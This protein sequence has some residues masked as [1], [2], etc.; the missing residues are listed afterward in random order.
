MS[1]LY[2]HN[3]II[4]NLGDEIM[5]YILDKNSEIPLYSQ[6]KDKIINKINEG[7]Y[8]VGE[9]LPSEKEL[10]ELYDVS[11][12]TVRQAID[13]LVRENY[14]EIKRG[15]GTFVKQNKK[16]NIWGL[17][18]LRSFEE[19]AKRHGL[20]NKTEVI[21]IV[22][23]NKNSELDEIFNCKHNKYYKL[24]RL[25]YIEEEPSILVDTYIPYDI[26]P[27][28]DKYDFSKLS[29]F[30]V[31]KK[32]Y[33]IKIDYAQKTLLPIN[34]CKNEAKILNV[35]EG[36]AIQL[37]KT[38]IYDEYDKPFEYSISRDR[39]DMTRFYATLKYKG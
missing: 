27:G 20:K 15:I 13:V 7:E 16:F 28:L 18:E 37:V 29:L 19:E 26:A 1:L 10:I 11:R 35:E 36:K 9:K 3:S 30:Y 4:F 23:V 33:G 34:I 21:S 38:I 32:D 14:L 39:G 22:L 12:T 31:L 25:R 5:K 17:E 6:L 8:K 24:T 2:T